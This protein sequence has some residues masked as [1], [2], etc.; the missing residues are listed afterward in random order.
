MRWSEGSSHVFPAGHGPVVGCLGCR[1]SRH[2][3]VRSPQLGQRICNPGSPSHTGGVQP[4]PQT[5]TL[6]RLPRPADPSSS[7]AHGAL[8]LY[9]VGFRPNR[10]ACSSPWVRPLRASRAT[11]SLADEPHRGPRRLGA[12]PDT[13]GTARA[14]NPFRRPWS[15]GGYSWAVR[16]PRVASRPP[17]RTDI[18]D[19]GHDHLTA[20]MVAPELSSG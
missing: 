15:S 8:N 16:S 1:C 6:F 11:F 14:Y 12:G 4:C 19:Q 20:T 2:H 5:K 3:R 9:C 7:S 10:S 17:D 13:V 18:S